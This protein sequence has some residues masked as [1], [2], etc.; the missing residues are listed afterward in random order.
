MRAESHQR[1]CLDSRW[2]IRR[3]ALA[4]TQVD[5]RQAHSSR[6]AQNQ[7]LESRLAVADHLRESLFGDR[8]DAAPG[9]ARVPVIEDAELEAGDVLLD[10]GVALRCAQIEL[11]LASAADNRHAGPALA[12]IRL[13]HDRETARIEEFGRPLDP[14]VGFDRTG[15]QRIPRDGAA[16]GQMVQD[17]RFRFTGESARGHS[18]VYRREQRDRAMLQRQVEQIR[19]QWN[20]GCPSGPEFPADLAADESHYPPAHAEPE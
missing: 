11:E 17:F 13:Q 12:Y 15:N 16:C 18:R 8:E 7:L 10:D 19:N 5:G 14:G 2:N 3:R 6:V 9:L 4:G 20:V 1:G